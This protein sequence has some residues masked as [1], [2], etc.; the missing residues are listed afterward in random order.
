MN[1]SINSVIFR[2]V[3]PLFIIFFS[4]NILSEGILALYTQACAQ[5][6]DFQKA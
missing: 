5:V 2:L 6:L 4:E 1:V 3:L